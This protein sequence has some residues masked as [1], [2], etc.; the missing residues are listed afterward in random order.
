MDLARELVWEVPRV[1]LRILLGW[2]RLVSEALRLD[3]RLDLQS[4][5]RMGGEP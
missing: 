1:V 5:E 3:L 4:S 2:G